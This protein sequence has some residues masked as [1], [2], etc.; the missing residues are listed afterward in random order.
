MGP[1]HSN[2][3]WV[4]P[5][6]DCSFLFSTYPFLAW[7]HAVPL[8]MQIPPPGHCCSVWAHSAGLREMQIQGNH[9]EQQQSER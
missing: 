2:S 9:L 1:L 8:A 4:I 7:P 6:P 5:I 3:N